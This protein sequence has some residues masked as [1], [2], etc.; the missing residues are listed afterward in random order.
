MISISLNGV[1][2]FIFLEKHKESKKK[3]NKFEQ[4]SFGP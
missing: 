3:Q 2:I 4:D 1:R